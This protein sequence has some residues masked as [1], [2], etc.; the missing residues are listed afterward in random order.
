MRGKC[1]KSAEK[2][3]YEPEN[4]RTHPFSHPHP[5]N[6]A[7][8]NVETPNT[9]FL[10][11]ESH[12]R[13]GQWVGGTLSPINEASGEA[14]SGTPHLRKF[15]P[16]QNGF[17]FFA[18]MWRYDHT[19]VQWSSHKVA[20]GKLG[21]KKCVLA[22]QEEELDG[23]NPSCKQPFAV[24]ADWMLEC[25]LRTLVSP[26]PLKKNPG[27]WPTWTAVSST[28]RSMRALRHHLFP[29]RRVGPGLYACGTPEE[30][31]H[32]GMGPTRSSQDF[33]RRHGRQAIY[34]AQYVMNYDLRRRGLPMPF[35][36]GS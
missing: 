26:P 4:A 30:I 7:N 34:E 17:L 2:R 27:S 18:A 13:R 31:P 19:G 14:S 1:H 16:S 24:G 5:S 11:G 20:L 32:R 28:T 9:R 6:Q 21:P 12:T 15:W 36:V 3:G 33:P 10:G 35:T 23:K 22:S 8:T 25:G 29:R